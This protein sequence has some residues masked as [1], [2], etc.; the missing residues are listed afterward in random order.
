MASK[1][2]GK[3]SRRVV[4]EAVV[5]ILTTFNNTTVT[6]TDRHGDTIAWATTGSSGFK[7]TRKGTPYA[8]QVAAENA[9]RKAL[10]HGV[11]SVEVRLKGP[12]SGRDSSVRALNAMGM[13]ISR[14]TDVTPIPHNGC[15]AP[16][17]RR[18]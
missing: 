8:A 17:R 14:I 15:R 4:P 6:F 12:G 18:V 1:K 9:C 11:Q 10:E 2:G 3:K 16:K 13:S 5:H 7:G